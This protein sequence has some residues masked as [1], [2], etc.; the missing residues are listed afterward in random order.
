MG[1]DGGI[2]VTW[3]KGGNYVS[4]AILPVGQFYGVSYD[5]AVP[6][7]ICGGAQDNGSWCGPSRRRGA[8]SNAYWFTYSGGDGFWTAQ[9]PADPKIIYGESQGGAISRWNLATGQTNFIF[10][11]NWRP[12]YRQYEDSIIIVRGD[13][14]QPESKDAKTRIAD[15]RARQRADSVSMTMRFNW[16]TPYFLSPHNKDIVYI[17]GNRVLKSLQRGDNVFTI[18]PD[19]SKQDQKKIELSMRK[20]GG[21]TV[22][23]TGA[24]T[25]GTIVALAESYVKAG[26]IY[27]GT[28]DGNVWFTMNDGATWTQVDWKKF[29]GLA[30][31]EVYVSRIEPSHFDT[32]TWY[33]S[34]DNHRVNDFTP[35]VYVT[36]DGG[37]T[38]KSIAAGLPTGGP[39]YVRVIRE[40]P[41]NRDLLFAGTSV[42]VYVSLDRGEHW[43]K[44]MTAMPTVPIFDLKIHPR[45]RELIAATHGR[46][47]YIVDIAPLEQMAGKQIADVVLFEPKRAFQWGE[48]PRLLQSGNGD[49]QSIYTYPSP[50]YGAEIVYRLAPGA[51]PGGQVRIAIQDAAGDTIAT[52]NGP[53]AAGLQR[54]TWAYRGTRRLATVPP[55]GPA[56]LRDSVVRVR[57]ISTVLDSLQQ[58]GWD[59]SLV[60][61]ARSVLQPVAGATP[62]PLNIN[63]G[64]G[65]GPGS[66]PDRPA[67]GGVV[68]AGSS[69]C[70]ATVGGQQIDFDK[71]QTVNRLINPPQPPGGG[72]VFFGGGGGNR[73]T[74][75]FE[76]STG[77]YLVSF[78]VGDKVYKQVLR[79]ERVGPGE[80]RNA[81]GIAPSN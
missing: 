63:C 8:V 18:S 75:N 38:F 32:L 53:G 55:L 52:V 59:T 50:Q 9:D 6:Y 21:I 74:V 65:G 44:F 37:K 15:L 36:N 25:Y 66:S 64:G 69:G 73:G 3:D 58:S 23:A 35:Y 1:N 33:V 28:D 77:D 12:R 7:N 79:V 26:Q 19:L 45:D 56:D 60:K 51:A 39:D 30:G 22:D 49:G 24:E 70:T 13:T 72:I 61:I 4:S 54:V 10:P 46:N 11:Q 62:P 67:E 14:A 43:Q 76:A 42:G 5:F 31:N 29:A 71:Y 47:F 34:F 68:R 2:A 27:A 17:G 41:Y 80:V 81:Q 16:E 40:D 57:R 48:G 78:K 20:T